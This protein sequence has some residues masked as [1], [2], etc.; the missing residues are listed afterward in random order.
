MSHTIHTPL[1][2]HIDTLPLTSVSAMLASFD[3]LTPSDYKDGSYRL[4]RY[5]V[6]EYDRQAHKLVKQANTAFVQDDSLNE[7]QGN[8]ARHYDD[9]TDATITDV[10]F[11]RMMAT[12]AKVTNL[13]PLSQIA[14]H[15]MRILAKD[16]DNNAVATPEGIH[17]DGFDYVGV[18]TMAR[19]NVTGGELFI[20]QN[21]T[22]DAP[23]AM[24]DP[25]AGDFCVINDKQLWH[26]AGD[27]TPKQSGQGYWDL[28]V[29]TA[30]DES[31]K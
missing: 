21:K 16:A 19:H 31:V 18:F 3:T 14:V 8:V 6:F 11:G 23:M 28:F 9:L 1:T 20:W 29:L 27:V 4:R 30:C 10:D 26:S 25:S 13:P 22:D 15:Q 7:F 5:S 12:F 2:Y 17:Q 24:F